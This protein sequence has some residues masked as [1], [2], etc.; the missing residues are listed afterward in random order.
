MST[1]L[2]VGTQTYNLVTLPAAPGPAAIELAMTDTVARLTNPFTRQTQTQQWPGGDWWEAV[3]T[4]PPLTRPQAWAWEAFLA[5]TQ[6]PLNVFY[7]GDPRA[8]TP[9]AAT[10]ALSPTVSVAASPLATQITS[11]GWG[12]GAAFTPP[13][14]GDYLQIG[15]RL[16]RV[17]DI[18][19]S[20]ASTGQAVLDIWPSV[21][22]EG[23]AL[24]AA[25]LVNAPQGLFRLQTPR[26]SLQWSV[27]RATQISFSCEE[28]R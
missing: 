3:V 5:A 4:L 28:A 1:P 17:L 8:V 21:R 6:G 10:G 20:N 9:L 7:L 16:H 13:A 12:T 18:A 26:R 22:P 27:S 25:I 19:S 23:I 24:S 14:P 15:V 11:T 2:V